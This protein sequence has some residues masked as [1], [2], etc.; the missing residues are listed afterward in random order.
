[1][2]PSESRGGCRRHSWPKS[3][4]DPSGPPVSRRPARRRTV[5]F[6]KIAAKQPHTWTVLP[7]FVAQAEQLPKGKYKPLG[8]IAPVRFAPVRFAPVRFAP[9]R[10]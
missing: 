6:R 8:H 1:M 5:M 10:S 3:H 7:V 2:P 9:V 4:P